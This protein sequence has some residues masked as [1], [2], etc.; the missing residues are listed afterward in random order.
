MY[1]P[2]LALLLLLCS[3]CATYTDHVIRAN[4]AAIAGD[5]PSAIAEIN[6]LL[7]VDSADEMPRRW[8]ADAA[9]L[10]LERAVLQQAVTRYP[11]S[12][13]DLSA[14]EQ[15]I[16]LLDLT[17][18]PVGVLGGYIY[19]DTAKPYKAPP[20]ERLAL[21][22]IN[23][24]NYLAVGDLNGAAVEVRRFQTMREFLAS[25]RIDDH[26]VA[27][28]GSYLAGFVFDRRGEADRALRY[29]DEALAVGP[30]PSLAVP[31]SRLARIGNYRGRHLSS[32]LA[33]APRAAVGA[34]PADESSEILVVI[35]YGRVPVKVPQ[36]IPV[37]AAIGIAGAA[38]TDDVRWLSRGVAKMVVYPELSPVH[39]VLGPPT[40]RVDGRLVAAD[41]LIDFERVVRNEYQTIKP[42]I[43]AAALVRMAARAGIAEGARIGGRQESAALG[44]VLALVVEGALTGLDRPD[45]RSW[46]MLP[47]R[48][49]VARVQV[50]PGSH[51]VEV[52]FAGAPA[53]RRL[54]SVE[55]LD[56]GYAA[57]VVTEPR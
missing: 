33:S 47:G 22:A 8:G 2:W 16:E 25:E 52:T 44:E 48:V 57:V 38:V 28:F 13:R 49:A 46:T 15:E 37:G 12:A 50:P 39:Q 36:R 9:L 41:P 30:L 5:Y 55:V 34:A 3:G 42:K 31:A 27:S 17:T 6:E 35:S 53:A 43:I 29:Y 20:S 7:D 10:T 56:D 14:A 51:E 32:V 40:V 21:N 24:L 11:A 1:A 4:Q 26:G 19:S 54:G 45:T 18:D 23:V